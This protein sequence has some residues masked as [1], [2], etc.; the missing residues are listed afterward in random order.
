MDNQEGT[1]DG[2]Q[3]SQRTPFTQLEQVASDLALAITLQEQ[4]RAFTALEA[5]ESESEEELEDE[6]SGYDDSYDGDQEFIDRYELE[7]ELDQVPEGEGTSSDDDMYDLE[8]FTPD[9]L[10]YEELIAL[11]E[12]IGEEKKGLSITEIPTCLHPCKC[13]SVDSKTNIDRCVICQVE[14]EEGEVLFALPCEH[15]Y[16]SECISKWLQIRKTCP[17]CGTEVVPPKI[18]TTA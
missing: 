6:E 17:I 7:A 5:I 2:K 16:H 1:Q 3:S 14:Y 10:S 12:F 15:P 18:A 9:A 8:E 11:G 4:E 13:Q